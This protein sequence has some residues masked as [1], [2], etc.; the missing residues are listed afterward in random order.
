[1]VSMANTRPSVFGLQRIL[2]RQEVAWLLGISVT[3]LWRMVR[4]GMFP[5]A[6]RISPGR[7]GWPARTV[8][9]WIDEHGEGT[10]GRVD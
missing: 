6:M 9:R 2:S 5:P 3:T 1:M 8:A 4:D 10:Q 7:V